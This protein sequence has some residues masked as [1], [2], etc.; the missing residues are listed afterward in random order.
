M[1]HVPIASRETILLL[2]VQMVVLCDEKFTDNPEDAVALIAKGGVSS[3]WPANGPKLIV[4]VDCTVK[5]R[6]TA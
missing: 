4:C 2:T 1:V 3:G 6:V 5:L